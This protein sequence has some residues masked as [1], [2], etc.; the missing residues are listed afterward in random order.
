MN[1]KT[2]K[3]LDC[4]QGAQDS[5]LI[6]K[7]CPRHYW[8]H[9]AK[10]NAKKPKAK[11]K[12]ERQ[13]DLS[14][15][16]ASQTLT[17]PLFCEECNA[18]LPQSPSWMRKACIAHILPKRPDYGFPSVALHPKNKIFL[19]PDCHTNMDNLG[20]DRI[21]KMKTLPVMQERVKELIPLLTQAELNRLPQHFQ[22]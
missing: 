7:R 5:P 22:Q 12:V 15:F 13:K 2:G 9:R 20:A 8:E 10:I 16:F 6:A 11:A 17:M 4:P 1:V 21:K 19:C 18:K 14:V 3:C